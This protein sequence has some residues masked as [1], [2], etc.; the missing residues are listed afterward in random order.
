MFSKSTKA[1][2]NKGQE[3]VAK[4]FFDFLLDPNA[5][6]F[7]I[8]GPGGTVKTFYP[9]KNGKIALHPENDGYDDLVVDD[10]LIQGVVVGCMKCYR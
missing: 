3:A 5:S 8:S 7:N 4:E 9:Q 10:C 2:L 6:E 1:P